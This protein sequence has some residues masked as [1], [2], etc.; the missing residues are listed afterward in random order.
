MPLPKGKKTEA[1]T[2]TRRTATNG[3][4]PLAMSTL[5]FNFVPVFPR[6]GAYEF[7][8]LANGEEVAR[9]KFRADVRPVDR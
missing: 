6:P 5:M 1:A 3:P 9:L 8:L 7:L 2:A 4:D